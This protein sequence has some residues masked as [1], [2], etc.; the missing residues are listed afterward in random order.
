MN[1][2]EIE[3]FLAIIKYSNISAA[4]ASLYISQPALSRR[5]KSLETDL[6]YELI[7][8]RK[9]IRTA[10][11]TEAGRA[12]IGIAERWQAL[13]KETRT[14]G[15]LDKTSI[16]NVTSVD[17]VSAYLLAPVC[18]NFLKNAQGTKLS[19]RTAHSLEA[20]EY[21]EDGSIDLAFVSRTRYSKTTT[22]I[23][24]FKEP[25]RL[26]YSK[27]FIAPDDIHP[28]KLNARDEIKVSWNMEYED[29]HDY[30][31][32]ENAQPLIVLDEMALLE[33][34]I[35]SEKGWA[36]VPASMAS[37]LQNHDDIVINDMN[38]APKERTIYLLLKNGIK[39]EPVH[40]FLKI[41]DACLSQTESIHPISQE[42]HGS[43]AS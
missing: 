27:S 37:H 40:R 29:W 42:N 18:H 15:A 6:G 39:S 9:G 3:A 7:I 10:E 24:Y 41:L 23:P 2:L 16:L 30:W 11:L 35:I 8:R 14:F 25:M 20:Y 28:S 34:F 17:S 5:I 31:F 19:L 12:F 43:G 1:Q 4:A 22:T 36:I 26:I 32:G 33:H 21:M 38:D 13:V